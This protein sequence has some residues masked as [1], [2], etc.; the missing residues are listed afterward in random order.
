[1]SLTRRTTEETGATHAAGGEAI[2]PVG[3]AGGGAGRAVLVLVLVAVAALIP[4]FGPRVALDG[5]GEAEAP[6]AGGIALLRTVLLAALCVPVGELFVARL[7][8]R[9]PGAPGQAPRSWAPWAAGAGFVASLGLASAVATG[10]LVPDSPADMDVGG[11]HETRDGTLAL[12]EVNA[13]AAAGLLALSRRPAAQALPLAAVVVA[14]ALR[15]H[16]STDHHDPLVGTGL[17]LVHLTCAALWAGGLLHVLRTLRTRAWRSSGPGT[18]L[19]GRYARVATVLLAAVTASGVWSTLRRMPPGTVLDQLT[20]TAY[21]RALFAKVV[22]VAAVAVLALWARLRLRRATDDPL[23]ACAPARVEVV[24]L[25]AVVA[26]SAL[27]TAL[28]LPIRW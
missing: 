19:L 1:M 10:N 22:L 28:P 21:G 27:M 25:G 24:L 8:R 5:T 17:T 20:E 26:V 12:V 7:A 2:G 18:A 4:L 11:L 13:F 15:A 9:V 16:P 3:R 14:E 23:G 6:G